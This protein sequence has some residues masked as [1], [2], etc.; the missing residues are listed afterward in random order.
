MEIIKTLGSVKL[1]QNERVG[2]PGGRQSIS[3]YLL[4]SAG[5]GTGREKEAP[6]DSIYSS[7]DCSGG[8]P[9]FPEEDTEAN[10]GR[11]SHMPTAEVPEG[12]Q[13]AQW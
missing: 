6:P 11:P 10:E 8:Q 2:R 13:V 1:H 5:K 9:C 3:R 7:H 12:L 4:V